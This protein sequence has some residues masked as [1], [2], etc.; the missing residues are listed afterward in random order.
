MRC[1]TRPSGDSERAVSCPDCTTQAGCP[2]ICKDYHEACSCATQ[3]H[4]D[5]IWD[6]GA[7]DDAPGGPTNSND[8]SVSCLSCYMQAKC[9]ADRPEAVTFRPYEGFYMW[10][11]GSKAQMEIRFDKDLGVLPSFE[12][13]VELVCGRNNELPR[14]NG[15]NLHKYRVPFSGLYVQGKTLHVNTST[16]HVFE[17]SQCQ[18]MMDA[19]VVVGSDA[20]GNLPL[21]SKIME[22]GNYRIVMPDH[23]PP[24]IMKFDPMSAA[25]GVSTSRETITFKFDE[26]IR[27]RPGFS[28]KL[29]ALA[30]FGVNEGDPK[31][32]PVELLSADRRQLKLNVRG[33][34]EPG[35]LYV[36]TVAAGSLEDEAS[37]VFQGVLGE[38]YFFRAAGIFVEERQIDREEKSFWTLPVVLG[39][40][41]GIVLLMGTVAAVAIRFYCLNNLSAD[42]AKVQP[43]DPEFVQN[44][45]T[46]SETQ[47]REKQIADVGDDLDENTKRRASFVF[48]DAWEL[49]IQE[50]EEDERIKP[51]DRVKTPDRHSQTRTSRI[52]LQDTTDHR[53]NDQRPASAPHRASLVDVAW[54]SR[55]IRASRRSL[56]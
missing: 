52:S 55:D 25:T 56:R 41:G 53:D 3:S 29:Q 42:A 21:P 47:F 28:A 13:T 5:W 14:I 8:S 16:V 6:R 4:C 24:T 49:G 32:L 19:G 50:D 1:L 15:G 2:S 31:P 36:V 51:P 7:C 33:L 43:E 12:S 44:S 26:R 11:T 38:N 10:K 23:V 45:T 46:F 48:N 54:H 17:E 20:D 39:L 37:N 35:K 40:T 30:I 18:V 22:F 27:L 34:L 9:D